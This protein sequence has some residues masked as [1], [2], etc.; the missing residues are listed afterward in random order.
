M[1]HFMTGSTHAEISKSKRE[2]SKMEYIKKAIY[3]Q[4]AIFQKAPQS[5]FKLII[6]LIAWGDL[7]PK[8]FSL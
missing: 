1:L 3:I 5:H 4:M 6:Q 8:E 7:D 2:A